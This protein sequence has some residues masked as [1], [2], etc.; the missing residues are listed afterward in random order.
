MNFAL[1]ERPIFYIG[2]HY[3]T[4][5]GLVG[6]AAFFVLGLILARVFQSSF[7]RR[8]FSRFKLDTSFTA[9]VTMILSLAAVVFCTVSAINTA[10]IPLAWSAPLP[11]INLSLLQI[12]LLIA[13]LIAVFWVSSHT[14]RFLFNR[15][16][17]NS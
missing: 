15:F 2:G 17:A 1:L 16:L 5:L 12:F 7:V 3:V 14:K 4:T 11:A 13:M 8:L 10:G 9:I 6:A